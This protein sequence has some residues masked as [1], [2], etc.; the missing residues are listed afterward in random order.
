MV[1]PAELE[2]Y[3]YESILHR[4]DLS[5]RPLIPVHDPSK[6]DP[7]TARLPSL[8]DSC[9]R[10]GNPR[11]WVISNESMW[12]GQHH[13]LDEVSQILWC[14]FDWFRFAAS[15]RDLGINIPDS[16]ETHEC[17]FWIVQCLRRRLGPHPYI[18]DTGDHVRR[19]QGLPPLKEALQFCAFVLQN[20]SYDA[21]VEALDSDES[22]TPEGQPEGLREGE[23][24]KEDD[25]GDWCKEGVPA[26]TAGEENLTLRKLRLTSQLT[27]YSSL[28]ID[29]L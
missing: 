6:H 25:E 7:Q 5:H 10:S 13:V 18:S 9:H 1:V 3:V 14:L 22:S 4:P 2:T 17:L 29:R 16:T 11:Y 12:A 24:C 8:P 20:P 27:E 26:W 23:Y 21:R 15:C 19:R 28:L